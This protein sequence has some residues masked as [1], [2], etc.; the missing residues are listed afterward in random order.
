MYALNCCAIALLC[1]VFSR[2]FST[3]G[4][5]FAI[6]SAM[7]IL[8]VI[9]AL[10]YLVLWDKSFWLIVKIIDVISVCDTFV[11]CVIVV[12]IDH[13]RAMFRF[14]GRFFVFASK[15]VILR[16]IP[17]GKLL[18]A[19]SNLMVFGSSRSKSFMRCH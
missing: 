17:L 11:C 13:D 16:M 3:S 9:E 18:A 6:C 7:T 19:S 2:T 12:E 15:M 8:A 5:P 10:H 4:F 14:D 1:I